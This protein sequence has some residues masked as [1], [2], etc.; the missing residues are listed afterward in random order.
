MQSLHGGKQPQMRDTV[1]NG[2]VQKLV[3]R[4]GIPKGLI[5]VLKERGKYREGMK[6]EEMRAELASHTDFKK[7]KLRLNIF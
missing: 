5:Q 3:L 2:K 7:E 4:I 6:L 1:W